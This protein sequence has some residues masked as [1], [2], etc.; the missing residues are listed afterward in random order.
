QGLK[1]ISQVLSAHKRYFK[2]LPL[3]YAFHST[4][5][6]MIAKD[7]KD[8]L[9]DLTTQTPK[10]KF[11]SSLAEFSS[12][13]LLECADSPQEFS[14]FGAE[15]WWQNI[16]RPVHFVRTI[17]AALKLGVRCFL[18]VSPHAIL[19]QYLRSGCKASGISA[20]VAPT[21]QRKADNFKLLKRIW[22]QL[23]V[24]GWPVDLK[25]YVDPTLPLVETPSYPWD[26]KECRLE[27][28]S[29][30]LGYLS[31]PLKHP[32]LG[33]AKDSDLYEQELDIL[34]EPWLADHKVGEACFYPAACF[35][36]MNIA[37]GALKYGL[38]QPLEMQNTAILRPVIFD[39]RKSTKL[40]TCLESLDGEIRIYS[41]PLMQSSDWVLHTRGRILSSSTKR[42]AAL[43]WEQISKE[44]EREIAVDS[45][46]A[47]TRQANMNYGPVFQPLMH[48]W[49][50]GSNLWAEFKD[51]AYKEEGLLLSPVL[52]DGAL[53]LI[54]QTVEPLLLNAKAPV[55]PYWFDRCRLYAKGTPK[56]A[57][58]ELLRS[59]SRNVVSNITL[60]DL[61]G[62]VLFEIIRGRARLVPRLGRKDAPKL[63]TTFML[64]ESLEAKTLPKIPLAALNQ[65]QTKEE[66]SLLIKACAEALVLE[67]D[68]TNSNL[69][70]PFLTYLQK[71]KANLVADLPPFAAIFPT[72][73]SDYPLEAETEMLLLSLKLVLKENQA[74]DSNLKE[75]YLENLTLSQIP[76]L[77]SYLL[78]L[79]AKKEPYTTIKIALNG[80]SKEALTL[81]NPALA[82]EEVWLTASNLS[83]LEILKD[84]AYWSKDKALFH[85]AAWDFEKEVIPSGKVDVIFLAHTLHKA[86]DLKAAIARL[87]ESL[88]PG[89]S[90]VVLER[91]P[92]LLQ[93]LINGGDESWWATSS[94][95]N[96]IGRLLPASQWQELFKELGFTDLEVVLN[97]SLAS[98]FILKARLKEEQVTPSLDP[99]EYIFINT[100][101][102]LGLSDYFKL[103]P[104]D[105]KAN[106]LFWDEFWSNFKDNKTPILWPLSANSS[107][108]V[109]SELLKCVQAYHKAEIPTAS[110][111]LLTFGAFVVGQDSLG[112]ESGAAALGMA[113]VIQNEMPSLKLKIID[114]PLELDD[115]TRLAL[116][117]ELNSESKENEVALR[118][119]ARFI[120]RTAEIK[121]ISAK[122][123]ENLKLEILDPGHLESLSWIPEPKPNPGP[124]EVVVEMQA[125]GLNFR[126]VMWAMNLLPEEALEQG[127]SGPG[128]GIEG[129][130]I[131]KQV[132]SKVTDLKVGARVVC[133]GPN[134]FRQ[135]VLTKAKACA[136]IPANLSFAEA[137][138]IPVTFFTAYYA[139][140]HLAN[141]A[142]GERLLIHGAAGGVG[143]AALALA[144][145]LGVEVYATA[146]SVLKRELLANLGVTH[147][148]DSRSL[149]FK[150]EILRDT[151]GE[152][153]DCVLNSLA[154]EALTASLQL[155]RPFGRFLELGKSDF[156]ADSPLRLKPFANN[157]SYFG[158]DVDQLMLQRADLAHKLLAELMEMFEAK[159]LRPLP[160]QV[161]EAEAY[162][163]AFRLMQKSRHVGKIV[164]LPPKT[165]SL[166]KELDSSPYIE[167][168]KEASYLISGGLAGF[169]LATAEELVKRGAT[170]LILVSRSG[171]NAN[172]HA[173]IEKLRKKAEVATLACDISDLELLKASLAKLS[174]SL[175]PI[176]GV[177]HAAANLRDSMLINLTLEDLK[178]SLTPKIEG[179]LVL[180]KL[181]ENWELDF[182]VVYS[183][184]TT[185]LGNP[186]QANYV[187]GNL[188]MENLM[189]T[190]RA[191]GRPGLALGWGAI[192]DYGM[193]LRDAKT[194]ASI[195]NMTGM[196][197][198]KAK[199]ALEI[200]FKLPKK[201]PPYVSVFAADT[202]KLSRLPIAKQP[203]FSPLV[204]GQD[205]TKANQTQNLAERLK[206]LSAEEAQ[207]LVLQE[208][209]G[210]LAKILRTPKASLR[211]S[212]PLQSMGLDSLMGVELSLGLEELCGQPMSGS[213]NADLTPEELATQIL[214]TLRQESSEIDPLED[215]A[216][217][218]GVHYEGRVSEVAKEA[219][220][221]EA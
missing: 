106:P 147:I 2:L 165:K 151:Q 33:Y 91:E 99:K 4:H 210:Q 9:A 183:S 43:N 185:I 8:A 175:P 137:A 171:E 148:Y 124:D 213:L 21:M 93:D 52:I 65:D 103:I 195:Q 109:T 153:V 34:K 221:G 48:I 191:Q 87:K 160:C 19:Q 200:L 49:Q 155:L 61:E 81:L 215:L 12:E 197:P 22:K 158:I 88:R 174:S 189:A 219:V 68:L 42:P 187:A 39:A 132:G 179:A 6:E 140:K 202:M 57:R 53:Q 69:K 97:N 146:G 206:G 120:P 10:A 168:K 129:A 167:V 125:C 182:F 150:D 149:S 80:L 218:H 108:E 101:V 130:G 64:P 5:M 214:Q 141:L 199:E 163:S 122:P 31:G 135:L 3:D 75:R 32:L 173:G 90:L 83:H 220:K 172:N 62:Q 54:L 212:Q 77:K 51:D 26:R 211:A 29:E 82:L 133:F 196:V 161:M 78:D 40:K 45:F 38:E 16:R 105:L 73:L 139:L 186:G 1:A 95:T 50:Q 118:G 98:Q 20:L 116:R 70:G 205:L 131:I 216:K 121:E 115:E 112:S 74:L 71:V 11:I 177:I 190:R 123:W 181:S 15:Y 184:V 178:A 128:L 176:K 92:S 166:E 157:I 13:R 14:D 102:D 114:L 63:Y 59:S 28:T 55:L 204:F 41:R 18:E 107:L 46:Y 188:A 142:R 96:P 104:H 162:E 84:E 110:L 207:E 67:A 35:L 126:D 111:Y 27:T 170:H 7:L 100:P 169:G 79:K 94:E 119:S 56:Y 36:E 127:F 143:L 113:R 17:K 134:C 72:L 152:G 86:N 25:S 198:L 144:E 89:G 159:R 136:L 217:V 24:H 180:D 76:V 85:Y 37:C 23:L 117:G 47:L 208:V 192:S 66:A 58:V 60:F 154:G 30:C 201:V 194:L 164:L 138:T 203:R 156:Y 209:L 44:F 193:L 145:V